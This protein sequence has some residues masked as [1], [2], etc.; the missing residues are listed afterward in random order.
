[1]RSG[2]LRWKVGPSRGSR[3]PML[4]PVARTTQTLGVHVGAAALCVTIA[5]C[6]HGAGE[7]PAG[8][9]QDMAKTIGP[10]IQLTS[11]AFS[12]GQSIPKRHTCDGEDVS[13]ALKWGRAP[14]GTRTFALVCDDPD[15]PAGTWVHWVVY[16]LPASTTELAE[17][18]PKDETLPGG[19]RQGVNDFGRIGYGG[20]CPPPGK[21]HRYVFKLYALDVSPDLEPRPTKAA[22]MKAIE[23]HVLGQGQLIGTYGRR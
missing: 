1:M 21:P 5:A 3:R 8:E 13:P 11:P 16:G 4:E 14:E 15:A 17:N 6:Q 7:T 12:E 20:P 23:G 2:L 10:S 19:G 22:L 18:V 9:G